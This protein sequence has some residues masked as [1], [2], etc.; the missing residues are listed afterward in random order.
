[1][2]EIPPQGAYLARTCPQAVQLNVLH[3][4]EP[5]PRSPFME[6]LGQGGLDF[7]VEVFELLAAAVPDAVVIDP[8][9]SR[10]ASEASTLGAM[11]R[12]APLVIGG[13]LP[14]DEA[15]HRAGKPDLLVRSNAFD[16][17]AAGNGYLPGDV[18]HHGT[19]RIKRNEDADGAVTSSLESIFLGPSDP[20]D[21]LEPQWRWPDL[22]QLAHYQRLLEVSGYATGLG[23]WAGIVGRE[24]RVVWYDLDLP[25]WHPSEYIE[26]PPPEPLST[27][28]AYDLEFAHRLAVVDASLA[29]RSDPAS[30]LLAEPI[31]V[32]ECGECGWREWCFERLEESAD[33]SLLP[34]MTVA[35]RRK[36]Q[37]RGVTTMRELA[38][39][40]STTARL[41]SAGI[42]LEHLVEKARTSDPSTPVADL[43]SG[44]PKQTEELEVEGIATAADVARLDPLIASFGGAGLG[45]LSQQ[46]DNARA[47][48]GPYPAYRRRGIDRVVVPRADIEIDVDMESVN[49]GCYLW[50]TLLNVRGA[51][52]PESST[53]VPFASWNPDIVVGELEA[54]LGFWEWFS[55]LRHEAARRGVT[56]RAYC[57]SQGAENGQLRRLAALCE[58][59]EEVED[60]LGSDQWVDL[61]PIVRN[62][63]ITGRG[64]G[65]KV[66]APMT[67]FSWRG[68]EVGGQLAMVSYIEATSDPDETV[69]AGAQRWILDYNED[70]VRATAALRE[71][72]DQRAS[73]LPSIE[74]AV[75]APASLDASL[76]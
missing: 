23:R 1:M 8:D 15:A 30:P 67:G 38:S 6:M 58:L 28:R 76:G 51:A 64:M 52:G 55:E 44:R 74:E 72:L 63:L 41:V 5:L 13:R 71:W 24:G 36:C 57:Y 54:F 21:E 70:D 66:V 69:R 10:S 17:T 18:K 34:G 19:L 31:A 35:K 4:C 53:F 43:M 27:M 37:L 22:L 2:S 62:Q 11:E 61:L 59:E 7:E 3:P 45:D 60:L 48:L 75:P 46:I 14:V 42:D 50:G 9:L 49:E 47:R 32:H 73:M 20:D 65:L 12:S 39:L 33:L 56:F 25:V 40:D 68:P 26:D 29:H 16:T